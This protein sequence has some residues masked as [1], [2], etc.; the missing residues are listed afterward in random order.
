MKKIDIF[1]SIRRAAVCGVCLLAIALCGCEFG[2]FSGRA[3]SN[4]KLA[5]MNFVDAM[6]SEE[7]DSEA[8]AEAMN[9][10]GNYSTMGFEKYTMVEDDDLETMLFD[11]L[12]GSYEVEF[13]DD[14]LGPIASPY[15][16]TDL[17]VSGKKAYVDLTFTSLNLDMMTVPLAEAVGIAGQEKVYAG[18]KFE[19]EE[20]ALVVVEEVF[21]ETFD[22]ENLSEY[23]VE[24]EMTLELTFT[25]DGWKI[26]VSDEF[27]D[28][29][30]G[31]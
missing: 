21:A 8:A 10:I 23:C 16:G 20:S 7:F 27:Y 5:I 28:A 14:D 15:Q 25:D 12:R 1:A 18:E 11:L 30:L 9:Y 19:T 31:R 22:T 17:K 26:N 2:T 3:L 29:L 4:P 24:R 6:Q 13:A